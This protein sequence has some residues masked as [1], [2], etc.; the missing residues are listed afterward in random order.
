[1]K[2]KSPKKLTLNRETVALLDLESVIGGSDT[3]S[4]CWVS[5]G[6]SNCGYCNTTTKWRTDCTEI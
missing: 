2:K 6:F 4:G 5:R 1:M 3:G